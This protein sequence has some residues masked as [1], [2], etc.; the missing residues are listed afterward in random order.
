MPWDLRFYQY[1][2][3]GPID[4]YENRFQKWIDRLKRY[5]QLDWE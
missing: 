1:M 3:G 4:E 2:M 5:I